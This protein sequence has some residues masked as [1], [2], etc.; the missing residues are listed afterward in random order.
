VKRNVNRIRNDSIWSN[1]LNGGRPKLY[2]HSINASYTLPLRFLPF[3]DFVN[4]Q[5]NY[6]GNYAW[7]AAPLSVQDLGLGNRIQNSQ[8]RQLTAD[9]DFVKLYDQISFLRTIN[10]PQRSSRSR[11]SSRDRDENQ[12]GEDGRRKKRNAGPSSAV[13]AIVRPLMALR[14]VRVNYSEDFETIIPGFLP[15]PDFLGQ[16]PGFKA[17]RMGVCGGT[18]ARNSDP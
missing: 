2:R 12:D 9:L 13:R 6:L 14:R 18:T 4:V 5:A 8:S 7:N 10:R 3:L 1:L 15:E 16:S 17:P 11:A